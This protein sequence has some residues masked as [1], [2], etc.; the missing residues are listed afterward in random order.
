MSHGVELMYDGLGRRDFLDLLLCVASR[1]LNGTSCVNACSQKS[2]TCI[3]IV[4]VVHT[5]NF[6]R[7]I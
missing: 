5:Y 6:E 4:C 2:Y 1:I 7:N 3:Y